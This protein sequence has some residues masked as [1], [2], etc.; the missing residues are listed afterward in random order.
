MDERIAVSVVECAGVNKV[1]RV[2]NG[3]PSQAR[4]GLIAFEPDGWLAGW[5]VAISKS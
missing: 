3:M 2:L 1:E 4:P 5:M